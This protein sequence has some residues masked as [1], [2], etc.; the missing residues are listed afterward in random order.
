MRAGQV[1]L[2]GERLAIAGLCLFQFPL[3]AKRVA[4]IVVRRGQI[5]LQREHLA[6]ASDSLIEAS[7]LMMPDR[8]RKQAPDVRRLLHAAARF[9]GDLRKTAKISP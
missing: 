1:R 3:F 9:S 5:R 4:E 6:V 7:R 2:K 8:L